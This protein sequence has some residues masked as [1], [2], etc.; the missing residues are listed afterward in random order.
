MTYLLSKILQQIEL[1]YHGSELEVVGLHSLTDATGR[2]LSFF[3]NTT[4]LAALKETKAGAVLI[5]QEH[6][7]YLPEGVIP[8]LT[9]DPYL[10]MALLSKIF[11]T[12]P[13]IE[14]AEPSVGEACQ[15][16][17]GVI[18][19]RGVRLG[20]RVT[21]MAGCVIGENTVIGSDTILYPNVSL[22]RDTVL[23]CECILHSGVVI[24]ADGYGFA[25][26]ENGRQVKIYQNGN[27]RIGDRVEI[28]ANSTIDRAAF[29]STTIGSGTKIDNL[30]QIAHNCEI[31]EDC[32]LV[33]QTALAGSTK[34]GDGV[35]MGGQSGATGH[36]EIG[37]HA[38]IASRAG[39]TKSLSGG[40]VYGGFPA[41]EQKLW[42]KIQAKLQRL[43]K[44][45]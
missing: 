2:H 28:G 36:L 17:E 11:H 15:I 39:V 22:Y 29:G 31:G 43:I 45:K 35:V 7:T 19:A 32:L 9:E 40:K 42:L 25:A 13:T 33:C 5:R 18:C 27:V 20:D 38:M 41:I 10:T 37:D 12:T 3:E 30:V 6:L 1:P 21:I 8:V 14:R 4:Y 16:A 23:G 34:L 44:K 24:G 26:R